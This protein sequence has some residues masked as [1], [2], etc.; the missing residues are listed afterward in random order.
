[1]LRGATAAT[2]L[3]ALLTCGAAGAAGSRTDVCYQG[4]ALLPNFQLNGSALLNGTDLLVTNNMSYQN[5]SIMYIPRF[6]STADLHVQ[7]HTVSG[8]QKN[9]DRTEE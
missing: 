1:M 8:G 7:L 3:A 9:D 6:A 2:L 5:A 4:G